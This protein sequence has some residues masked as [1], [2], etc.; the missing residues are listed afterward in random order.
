MT[1]LSQDSQSPGQDFNLG[2]PGYKA[3]VLTTRPRCSVT[4][5]RHSEAT[6]TNGPFSSGP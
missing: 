4:F 2:P 3:G 6:E 1:N 5:K